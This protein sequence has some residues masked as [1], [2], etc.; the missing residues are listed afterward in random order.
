LKNDPLPLP[1]P[2]PLPQ[3]LSLPF[4]LSLLLSPSPPS[5]H[6]YFFPSPVVVVVN[7]VPWTVMV[8]T[9][10]CVACPLL[11]QVAAS[12]WVRCCRWAPRVGRPREPTWTSST[13]VLPPRYFHAPTHPP[14]VLACSL[15][16]LLF[17]IPC[18]SGGSSLPSAPV[19]HAPLLFMHTRVHD[20][21]PPHH[22]GNGAWCLRWFPGPG[23]RCRCICCCCRLEWCGCGCRR[24]C[25]CRSA[26]EEGWAPLRTASVLWLLVC[27]ASAYHPTP[28]HLAPPQV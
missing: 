1:L 23:G 19:V 28:Q 20:A 26:Q 4:L 18:G 22:F 24:W 27:A 11:C 17:S 21:R 14:C 6:L 7:V 25:Q 2:F 16:A 15:R 10:V 3:S 13:P 5:L 9:A 12:V 8:V